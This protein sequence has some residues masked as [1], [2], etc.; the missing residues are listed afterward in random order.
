RP[1]FGGTIIGNGDELR[2][3]STKE[4][5]KKLT[6][7]QSDLTSI[8]ETT[9][10]KYTFYKS[11]TINK[12]YNTFQM[13]R[14][15]KGN[16]KYDKEFVYMEDP[17][18]Y[19]YTLDGIFPKQAWG[20]IIVANDNELLKANYPFYEKKNDKIQPSGISVFS[21]TDNGKSWKL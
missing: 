14:R 17:I 18:G 6:L 4:D 11:S 12:T 13:L 1:L 7:P 19:R 10:Q 20:K 15:K 2:F 5:A 8:K 9:K 3:V 21:S 16:E